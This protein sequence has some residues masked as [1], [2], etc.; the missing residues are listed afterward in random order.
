ML[1]LLLLL[2]SVVGLQQAATAP[3]TAEVVGSVVERAG[4]PIPG[5]TVTLETAGGVAIQKVVTNWTGGY[6]LEK[7]APGTY[8][9]K[10]ELSGF[11]T[12]T[13]PRLALVAGQSY[14][15]RV[16]IDVGDLATHGPR[17]SLSLPPRPVLDLTDDEVGVG[18][19]TSVGTFYIAVD[20]RRAP[21]TSANFLKYV[22]AGL[23]NSGRFHR[24]T[25]ADNY[26]PAPPARPMMNII[27]G[28]TNPA[29]RSEGFPAIP[30]ERTSV[31]GIKHVTGVVSMARGTEADTA[32]SDF[33]VLL[34]DQPSLDFG[35]Q[36]FADGQ[37]GAAFGRVV[38]GLDIVRKIQ[39]QPVDGQNLSA[40]VT[41]W[42]VW[43]LGPK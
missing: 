37:G 24:A 13:R 28:G 42:R 40:P 27:Q 35:G 29:K 4:G 38:E 18:V 41:I 8:S 7:I 34:D 6:R 10:V 17:A 32:T 39:Q 21:I 36:R 11:Q 33:F 22:A 23:Y 19:E 12:Y 15:L 9:V 14:T 20:T 3:A 25:R 2:A 5:V 30:L 31:T 16:G 26:T 43:R 1:G